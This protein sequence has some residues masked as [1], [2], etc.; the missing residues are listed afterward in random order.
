MLRVLHVTVVQQFETQEQQKQLAEMKI[1]VCGSL[2]KATL[3]EPRHKP[4]LV[5]CLS[6]QSERPEKKKSFP[7]CFVITV[8]F[9]LEK[10]V[11]SLHC[12]PV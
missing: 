6:S 3:C 1:I 5:M 12:P 11:I 7:A 4:K 2:V 10:E 8:F 9:H